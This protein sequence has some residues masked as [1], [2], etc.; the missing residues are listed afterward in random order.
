M[1]IV[2]ALADPAAAARVTLDLGDGV[3]LAGEEWGSGP[4]AVLLLHDE[5]GD[6]SDWGGL[7]AKLA[8]AGFRVL[9]LD[10]RGHGATAAPRPTTDDEWVALVEDLDSATSWLAKKG[11][12]DIHVV[13]AGAGANLALNAAATNTAIEDLVLL[14]PSLNAHG[15]KLS[16]AI[17][18]YGERPLF[19]AA[20]QDD[21]TSVKAATW[22]AD[23]AR[24]PKLLEV[25]PSGGSGARLLNTVSSL[26]GVLVTWLN[27]TLLAATDPQ[28]ARD[29]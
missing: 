13:G 21:P 18:G 3:L 27:G 24:G 7:G 8:T 2:F 15:L 23:Q 28:A 16:S 10:L 11:A 26:E 9:A 17:Q 22:L 29:L 12:T 14:S 25:Y 1:L 6:R 20:A 4:R 5:G 19:V